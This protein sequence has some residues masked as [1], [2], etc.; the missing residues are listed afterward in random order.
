SGA[1]CFHYTAN[2]RKDFLAYFRDL[3]EKRKD[4]TGNYENW[5]SAY[6]YLEAFT[7]GSCNFGDVDEKFCSNFKDYLLNAKSLRNEKAKLSPNSAHSYFNKLKAALTEAF[8]EKLIAENPA[9]RVKAIKQVETKREFLT[10]EELQ[11]L[12][13]TE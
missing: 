3:V 12:A 6:N 8:E 13:K 1:Y 5:Q 10:L 2:K 4:S 9:K 7:K 11:A